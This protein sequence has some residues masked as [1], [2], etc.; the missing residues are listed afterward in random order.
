MPRGATVLRN[1]WGTAPGLWLE[2]H[3]GLVIML[4]G[5]P[6]EMRNLLEHEVVPRLAATGGRL[7]DSL[8]RSGPPVSPSPTLAERLGDVESE[9]APLTLA[10]LPGLEVSIFGSVPGTLQPTK[11]TRG[12]ERRGAASRPRRRARVWRR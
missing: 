7:G 12:C 11:P 2:G 4:P 10:Y 1:R 5:V 8:P 3:A 9:I 6:L